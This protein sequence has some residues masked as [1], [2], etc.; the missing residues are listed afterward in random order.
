[1][2]SAIGSQRFIERVGVIPPPL[3][4]VDSSLKSGMHWID[5]DGKSVM[6]QFE[7]TAT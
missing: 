6:N 3:R 1:M 5:P 2:D 4:A 7:S